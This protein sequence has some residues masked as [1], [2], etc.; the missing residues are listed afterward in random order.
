MKVAIEVGLVKETDKA[1]M[2]SFWTSSN[3]QG[4]KTGDKYQVTTAWLPKSQIEVLS[5]KDNISFYNTYHNLK[6]T[7]GMLSDGTV[8]RHRVDKSALILVP[9]WLYKKSMIYGMDI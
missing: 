6:F 2:I 8:K 1:I 7:R 9:D 5:Q 4:F 3:I